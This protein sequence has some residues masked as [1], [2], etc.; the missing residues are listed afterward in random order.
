[1]GLP[2]CEKKAWASVRYRA[3]AKKG[4]PKVIYPRN[5][6]GP[7]NPSGTQYCM[8]LE[9]LSVTNEHRFSTAVLTTTKLPSAWH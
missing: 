7:T 8:S 9:M 4:P 3:E 2:A 6:G 5:R 1:M